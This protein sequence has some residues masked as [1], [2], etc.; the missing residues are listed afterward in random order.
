MKDIDL[1]VSIAGVTLKNPIVTASGTVGNG[2]EISRYYDL[3][4]LGAVCV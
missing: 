4:E 1:T 2:W 3:S